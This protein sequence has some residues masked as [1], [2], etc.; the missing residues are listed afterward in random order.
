VVFFG[1]E[2][3]GVGYDSGQEDASVPG[4]I[5][6]FEGTKGLMTVIFSG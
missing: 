1:L 4:G 6:L 5:G 2:D 3:Q